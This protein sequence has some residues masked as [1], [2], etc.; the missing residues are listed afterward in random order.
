[1]EKSERILAMH[2]PNYIPWL[3][4]FYKLAHSDIF[5]YLDDVQYP[6]G[7]SFSPRNRI[8]TPNGTAYLTIPIHIPG[9]KLGKALYSEVTFAKQGWQRK[10]LKTISL[11]YRRAAHFDEVYPFYE[12]IL[13]RSKSFVELNIDLIEACATYIGIE[14]KRIRLSELSIDHGLKSDLIVDLCQH[15]QAGVYLSGTGGGKDYN[16]DEKLTKGGIE[17]RYSEFMPT[18]YPQLWGTFVSHLSILDVLFN[19]GKSTRTLLDLD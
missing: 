17:L 1:M 2:Q 13:N 18:H 4:Y 3:G 10:H 6:R 9:G 16:D 5:V 19:C 12:D 7:Q 8:K 14:N 11:N 15:F